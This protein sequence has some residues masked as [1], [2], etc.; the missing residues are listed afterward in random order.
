[1]PIVNILGDGYAHMQTHTDVQLKSIEIPY[2]WR[3]IADCA[4]LAC[5]CEPVWWRAKILIKNP[6]LGC[7]VWD[8]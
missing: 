6:V 7:V 5:N 1:M 8:K 4:M 2:D 3:I